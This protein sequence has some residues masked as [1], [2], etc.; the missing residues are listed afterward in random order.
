[1]SLP[2][3][4]QSISSAAHTKIESVAPAVSYAANGAVFTWGAISFNQI[5]MFV[6]G[7]IGLATYFTGLYFQKRRETRDRYFQKRRDDREQELHK[8]RLMLDR[9]AE[10][11]GLE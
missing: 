2:D 4:V 11:S 9:Q 7:I 6:G 5:M 10:G 3:T 8:H 1:V